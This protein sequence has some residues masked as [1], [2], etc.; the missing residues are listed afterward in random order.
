MSAPR[1]L[2]RTG[3]LVGRREHTRRCPIV[4][5]LTEL[6]PGTSTH[7]PGAVTR[8]AAAPAAWC[9]ALSPMTHLGRLTS[10]VL[11]VHGNRDTDVP[12]VESVQA[13]QALQARGARSEL[14]LL[15]G[16]G[17]PIV[18]ENQVELGRRVTAWFHRWL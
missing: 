14:L 1:G 3:P 10:P 11:F 6:R 4:S 9:P 17:H 13:H 2:D 16:E 5:P 18:V 8:V 7:R 15:P 12:V